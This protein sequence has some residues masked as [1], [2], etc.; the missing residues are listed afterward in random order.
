MRR[1][2]AVVRKRF[3]LAGVA[4]ALAAALCPQAPAQSAPHSFPAA[5]VAVQAVPSLPPC[6]GCDLL[7]GEPCVA[8]AGGGVEGT[9]VQI[10]PG[11]QLSFPPYPAH[12]SVEYGGGAPN[13]TVVIIYGDGTIGETTAS[14]RVASFSHTYPSTPGLYK[15]EAEVYTSGC[16]VPCQG[17]AVV[18]AP[19]TLG[20]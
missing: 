5:V 7:D 11:G 13:S 4:T 20:P 15:V 12:F 8:C 10:V 9:L 1:I 16:I 18:F 19:L 2:A 3:A 14:N 6:P 17:A